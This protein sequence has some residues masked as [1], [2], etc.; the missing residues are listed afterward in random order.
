MLSKLQIKECFISTYIMSDVGVHERDLHQDFAD[1]LE[2]LSQKGE[3]LGH[4]GRFLAKGL[5][6]K[7][8]DSIPFLKPI[9]ADVCLLD[10]MRNLLQEENE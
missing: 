10:K 7:T 2:V 1:A 9:L 4:H 6:Y 5:C 8:L 3:Y